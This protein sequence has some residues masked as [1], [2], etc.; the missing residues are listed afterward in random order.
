MGNKFF[1]PKFTPFL[2]NEV[3]MDAS[4]S[5]SQENTESHVVDERTSE[6]KR[7]LEVVSLQVEEL[8]EARRRQ[9][10]LVSN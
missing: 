4:C 7:E 10:T 3:A 9:E 6:L 1:L 2:L 5:F 8:R